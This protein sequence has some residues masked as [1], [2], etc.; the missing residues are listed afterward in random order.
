MQLFYRP[1]AGEIRPCPALNTTWIPTEI[2]GSGITNMTPPVMIQDYWRTEDER[3]AGGFQLLVAVSGRV[4]HWQR[5]NT[6]I[7]IWPPVAGVGA[8]KWGRVRTFGSG[9]IKHV[10]G[11][12]QG[13][14]RGALD[15]V[16]EDWQGRMWHWRFSGNPGQWARVAQVPGVRGG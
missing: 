12:L 8:P 11:L 5:V 7:D 3:Q 2:F 4:Q 15:A 16:V 10:W 6:D 1:A 13:S 14:W 9:E